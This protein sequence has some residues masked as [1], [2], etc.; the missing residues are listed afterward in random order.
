MLA[1]LNTRF[2][3]PLLPR[4]IAPKPAD[5]LN[6]LFTV[7]GQEVVM[8]TQFAAAVHVKEL[9]SHVASLAEHR[10]AITNA[11]DLLISGI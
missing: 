2:V 5:R 9:G 11:L 4:E 1:Q 7:G 6:P 3:V 8:L 10:Y